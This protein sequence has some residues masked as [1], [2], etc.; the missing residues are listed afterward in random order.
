MKD[1]VV[2]CNQGQCTLNIDPNG[3]VVG[4]KFCVASNGNSFSI[5]GGSYCFINGNGSHNVNQSGVHW[6]V[7]LYQGMGQYYFAISG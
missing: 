1:K 5:S 3:W 4:D 6:L 2:V 7:L